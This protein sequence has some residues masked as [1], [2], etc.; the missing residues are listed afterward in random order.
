MKILK[1]HANNT[2]R[3][4]YKNMFGKKEHILKSFEERYEKDGELKT[5][6]IY[7][8]STSMNI[9]KMGY[10]EIVAETMSLAK[11]GELMFSSA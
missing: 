3:K 8:A 6:T 2:K 5:D 4:K 7:V 10:I 1:K 11:A 9:T